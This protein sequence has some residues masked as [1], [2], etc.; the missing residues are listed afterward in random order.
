MCVMKTNSS[1]HSLANCATLIEVGI[2]HGHLQDFV[3]LSLYTAPS[4][5]MQP[6][7]S[8]SLQLHA[9]LPNV[10]EH[11]LLP[12]NSLLIR[13]PQQQITSLEK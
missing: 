7:H 9:T 8:R 11:L 12:L 10:L 13:L 1:D 2:T 5:L 4:P 3:K 6:A